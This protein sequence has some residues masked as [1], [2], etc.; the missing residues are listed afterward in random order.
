L[1]FDLQKNPVLKEKSMKKLV[2]AVAIA[3]LTLPVLALATEFQ[4]IG[5]LG[6][7]GAGV[8]RNNGALTAYWNPAGGA[9]QESPFAAH[10][11][12]G[13]GIRGSDGLAENVD[14]VNDIKFDDVKTF[15]NNSDAKTV[16]N[17]VKMVA[18]IDDIGT[19]KGNIA[20][21]AQVPVG[22]AIN[23]F[24]F[25][26]YGNLEGYIRPMADINNILPNTI[27]TDP[28]NAS[29]KAT[30]VNDLY[31]AISKNGATYQPG[32]YFSATE[33]TNL[34]SQFSSSLAS[35]PGGL[36][37][38]QKATQLVNA[39]DIQLKAGNLPADSTYTTLSENLI[40]ILKNPTGSTFDRNTTSVMTKAIQYIEVPLSY[41]H[42]FEFGDYGRLGIG[43]TAKV[44]SGTVYQNQILLVNRPNND[45][46]GSN[47]LAKDINKN[48]KGSVNF[49]LDLG[50]LYKYDK[51]LS[52]GLVAKNINSPKFDAPDYGVPEYNAITKKIVTST[53]K[54]SGEDVKL[55][56][57]LRT[58]IA[59]EPLSW[60]TI[61]ADLDLT[62]NDTVAPG[63][64]VGSAAKSQNVGGGLEVHPYSWL[65]L[66]GGAYKNI[67]K[68]AD[69]GTILTAGVT[70]FILDID[71]AFATDTFKMGSS[72]IPQ[73]MK[74]QMVAS[75]TF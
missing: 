28:N 34:T 24:S 17:L 68:S 53:K 10:I 71:G 50:A 48:S 72:S 21:N 56:P 9:F 63:T 47:D 64:V 11:G 5:A 14:R 13:F 42:P 4:P 31:V 22:F 66:R 55:K 20:L 26:V 38:G 59:L 57:Q 73:E 74:I 18:I 39:I 44:I 46:T 30:S 67:A 12:V 7:G 69:I 36:T 61:A 70:L 49:G 19:R 8:A 37:A 25:G 43:A 45:S 62:S 52:V 58:G 65:R 3:G 33:R 40:P 75:F 2:T 41:G 54:V 27:S 6:M 60:L 35:D 32:G 51:W 15:N 1:Y 16:G 23:R 29:T